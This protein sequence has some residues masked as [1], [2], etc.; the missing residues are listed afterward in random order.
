MNQ[1][2][3]VDTVVEA[4]KGDPEKKEKFRELIIKFNNEIPENIERPGRFV[5]D[6]VENIIR[7]TGSR[8]AEVASLIHRIA[9]LRRIILR[10]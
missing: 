1:S 2:S 9:I 10:Y 7:L 8:P 3:V 5:D 6:F 4:Y